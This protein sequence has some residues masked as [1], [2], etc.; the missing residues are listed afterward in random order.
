MLDV[1]IHCSTLCRQKQ[2]ENGKK[3]KFIEKSVQ[4]TAGITMGEERQIREK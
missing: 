2:Q 3:G 1:L 4:I